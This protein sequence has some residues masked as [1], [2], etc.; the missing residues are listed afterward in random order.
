MVAV[1]GHLHKVKK[2]VWVWNYLASPLMFHKIFEKI[3]I[4]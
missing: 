2:S 1:T 3:Q 4:G